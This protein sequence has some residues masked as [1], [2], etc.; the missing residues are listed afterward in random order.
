MDEKSTAMLLQ[1]MSERIGNGKPTIYTT[2]YEG[3]ALWKRLSEGGQSH[4]NAIMDRLKMC[5]P[6]VMDGGSLRKRVR[7]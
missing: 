5:V 3:I 4:A 6:V 1:I 7:L 2:N